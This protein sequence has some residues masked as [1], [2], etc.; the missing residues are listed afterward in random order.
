MKYVKVGN[1][2]KV[3]ESEVTQEQALK[4]KETAQNNGFEFKIDNKRIIVYE[5]IRRVNPHI[6]PYEHM[7]YSQMSKELDAEQLDRDLEQDGTY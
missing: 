7:T 3:K 4:I 5:N 6:A 1:N 2:N